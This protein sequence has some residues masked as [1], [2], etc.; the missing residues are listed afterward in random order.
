MAAVRDIIAHIAVEAAQ[1]RRIC[2]HNRKQHGV[3]AGQSCLVIADAQGGKKNYCKECAIDILA[4]AKVKISA[5]E[6]EIKNSP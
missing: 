4:K 5:L 6:R 2:H 3:T 1:R